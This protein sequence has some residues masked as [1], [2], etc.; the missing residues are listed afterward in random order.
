MIARPRAVT[1]EDRRFTSI[2]RLGRRDIVEQ[3]LVDGAQ[4]LDAEVAVSDRFAA[5]S[6]GG[7]PGRQRQHRTSNRLV[8]EI[9]AFGERRSGRSEQPPV[10]RRHPELSRHA[11]VVGN[12]AHGAQRI[13]ETGCRRKPLRGLAQRGDAVV[14]AVERMPH[15]HERAGFGEEQKQQAVDDGQGLIERVDAVATS[16]AR[17]RS[18][19]P[20]GRVE[21]PVA[22][23]AA[24][25]GSVPLGIGDDGCDGRR[26]LVGGRKRL[27]RRRAS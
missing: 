13:P 8:V 25:C 7:G 9:A 16:T 12:A 17:Q 15:R 27:R 18:Q 1:P 6:V 22:Q 23:T 2:W 5:R 21:Y 20:L 11:A 24:D 14:V 3:R 26:G 10:E 4:L 19:Q